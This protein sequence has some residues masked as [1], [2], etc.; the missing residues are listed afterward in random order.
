MVKAPDIILLHE[1][2]SPG[3]EPRFCAIRSTNGSFF[4][5]QDLYV[6][7]V[8]AAS[9]VTGDDAGVSKR[10]VVTLHPQPSTLNPQPSTLNPAP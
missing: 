3:F 4:L 8:D 2:L 9:P 5:A 7:E 1:G 10:I 6:Q